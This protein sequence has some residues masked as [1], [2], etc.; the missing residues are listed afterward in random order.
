MTQREK[1][2]FAMTGVLHGI[3]RGDPSSMA[4]ASDN[5]RDAINRIP[6]AKEVMMGINFAKIAFQFAKK[7]APPGVRRQINTAYQYGIL[8]NLEALY[9]F[10]MGL[11]GESNTSVIIGDYL[12]YLSMYNPARDDQEVQD[13]DEFFVATRSH[14]DRGK[15]EDWEHVMKIMQSDEEFLLR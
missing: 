13:L 6:Y 15:F 10:V 11:F 3:S 9:G 5:I 4:R 8:G 14:N 12:D 7:N 2:T 1:D